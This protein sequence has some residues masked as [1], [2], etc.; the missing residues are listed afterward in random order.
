MATHYR[1]GADVPLV[2][3]E[4]VSWPMCCPQDGAR[5][6]PTGHPADAVA[7]R[8]RRFEAWASYY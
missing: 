5:H 3:L 8:E 4:E 7:A 1:L 6:H 2:C